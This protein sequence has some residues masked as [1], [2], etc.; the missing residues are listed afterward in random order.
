MPK[1]TRLTEVERPMPQAARLSEDATGPRPAGTA[2]S[3]LPLDGYTRW[4][5]LKHVIPASHE[6]VRRREL[7]GRFPKRVK[8]GSARCVAWKNSEILKWLADP[9][10]YRAPVEG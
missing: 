5:E 9:A 10:S 7:A 4:G 3:T 2:R 6:T 1:K 8:L